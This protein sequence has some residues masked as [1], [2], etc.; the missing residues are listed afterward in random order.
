METSRERIIKAINHMEPVTPPTYIIG[1]EAIERWLQQYHVKDEFDLRQEL[2]LDLAVAGAPIYTGPNVKLGLSI[3]GTARNTGG[4]EGVGYSKERGDHPLADSNSVEDI[5]HFAWPSPDDFDYKIVNTLLQAIPDKGR[6]AGTRYAIS[7]GGYDRFSRGN[8]GMWMPL[9]CTLF[10]LFGFEE[11]LIKFHSDPKMI[12]AAICHVETFILEYCRR[13][14]EATKGM[15]DIFYF[16]DDFATARGLMISPEHWRKYLKPTYRKIFQLAKGYNVKNYFHCCGQFRAVMPDLIDIGMDIWETCQV[17]LPGNEPEVLK[18]EYGQDITFCG[19]VNSQKT[20]P[21][22]TPEDV[23]AEVR[24]RVRV[25][26][27]GGGYICGP[28][29]SVL[30]DVPLENV[31]AMLDEARK[32]SR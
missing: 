13:V 10:E 2:G 4:S 31:L 12:E 25:L 9:L 20:L 26:G 30:P 22:G 15:I 3:W 29:H 8:R 6:W 14:L 17:H 24:D 27:K 28:D 11:T 5:E 19:A 18:R 23:R 21:Y 7:E 1:F 32:V 16:G